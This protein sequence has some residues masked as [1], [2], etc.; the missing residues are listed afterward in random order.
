[1][2]CD[3]YVQNILVS[4]Q[5]RALVVKF[6]MQLVGKLPL[7][8]AHLTHP[9]MILLRSWQPTPLRSAQSRCTFSFSCMALACCTHRLALL[10]QHCD[11]QTNYPALRPA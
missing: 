3:Q 2:S 10:F 1:M 5:N 7:L 6:H 8:R 11:K 9:A 4:V